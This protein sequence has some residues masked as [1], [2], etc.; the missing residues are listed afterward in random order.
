MTTSQLVLR[1]GAFAIVAVL[2][3]LLTQ[4]LVLAAT[5]AIGVQVSY[6]LALLSGTGVGLLLKFILDKR[7]VFY[8]AVQS[9]RAETGK[10]GRYTL[11]GIGTTLLFWGAETGFWLIWQTDMMREAGAILGLS[12]GYVV[13]Y[14][15]DKRFV[16]GAASDREH[17]Q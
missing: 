2:A 3:N 17:R 8:D 14:N 12:V 15:L 16:F 5:P 1:Y 11:T 7:W 4:R 9:A 10:F 13:K 6:G